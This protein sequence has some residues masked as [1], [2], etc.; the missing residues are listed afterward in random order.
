MKKSILT[1]IIIAVILTISIIIAISISTEDPTRYDK[2]AKCL[3]EQDTKMYG[4]YWCHFCASQKEEFGDSFKY[5]NY[6]ECSLPDRGGA[7]AECKKEQITGY[8][9]WEFKDKTKRSGILGLKDLSELTGCK[10]P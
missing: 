6:V 5:I 3:T 7:T 10:L 9:T 1:L 2:F 8:P 4:T